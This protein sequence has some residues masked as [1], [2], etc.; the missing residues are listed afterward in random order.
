MVTRSNAHP[1][2][3]HVGCSDAE[4][5]PRSDDAKEEAEK[6]SDAVHVGVIPG[7]D[8][9]VI[10]ALDDDKLD[11]SSPA[12]GSDEIEIT[13]AS[14]H[15]SQMSMKDRLA[16]EEKKKAEVKVEHGIL[17]LTDPRNRP[18]KIILSGRSKP[19]DVPSPTPD[20]AS[21]ASKKSKKKREGEESSD[22]TKEDK[23]KKSKK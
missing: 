2:C 21:L 18:L 9:Q 8:A 4:P 13:G 1:L 20:S 3:F 11:T 6:A 19:L 23:K 15:T 22:K 16:A 17:E 10:R 7:P 12:E 14:E 5:T